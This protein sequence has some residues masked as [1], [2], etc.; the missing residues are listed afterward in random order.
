[1][2]KKAKISFKHLKGS[3]N[4]S[5]HNQVSIHAKKQEAK[6]QIKVPAKQQVKLPY[7]PNAKLKHSG[8]CAGC[9]FYSFQDEIGKDNGMVEWCLRKTPDEEKYEWVYKKIQENVLIK[10]CPNYK[11]QMTL[12][13]RK[14][15]MVK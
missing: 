5:P 3:F 9:I 10:Q 1:M 6:Q 12:H 8:F 14:V 11:I 7:N 4:K 15:G 2:S 13:M